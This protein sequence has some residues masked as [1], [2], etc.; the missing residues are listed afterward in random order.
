MNCVTPAEG[1]H[2]ILLLDT[3]CEEVLTGVWSINRQYV[4]EH[5][6]EEPGTVHLFI[7]TILKNMMIS[8]TAIMKNYE[9]HKA[10]INC[11]CNVLKEDMILRTTAETNMRRMGYIGNRM[12]R[13]K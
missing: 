4:A 10:F 12:Q 3:S 8:H 7:L 2:G 9:I 6:Q 13:R 5:E 1:L 11:W